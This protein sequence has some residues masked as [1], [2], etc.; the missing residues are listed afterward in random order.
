MCEKLKKPK[1]KTKSKKLQKIKSVL[2]KN[3]D[4]NGITTLI[5][6]RFIIVHYMFFNFAAGLVKKVKPRDFFISTFLINI[7]GA[8][9]MVYLGS[10][11]GK[12]WKE[13]LFASI[14]AAVLLILTPLILKKLQK[15][16]V[17]S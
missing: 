14:I 6:L 7:I 12:S 9:S 5:I 17:D 2:N 10:S 4:E 1:S 16:R 13:V 15:R 8:F 3:L 11:L